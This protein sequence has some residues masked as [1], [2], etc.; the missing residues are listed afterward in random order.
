YIA[1]NH[2]RLYFFL[3]NSY[4]KRA[5]HS[6]LDSK[7]EIEKFPNQKTLGLSYNK[8][9][10]FPFILIFYHFP[11]KFTEICVNF[12]QKIFCEKNGSILLG[13]NTLRLGSVLS[14]SSSIKHFSCGH[15]RS[16]IVSTSNPK[17][18]NVMIKRIIR[19]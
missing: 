16:F 12:G 11:L 13:R 8:N 18:I 4:S 14:F 15:K 9:S 17:I 1:W 10:I 7:R 5:F 2:I 3:L 6:S 19:I